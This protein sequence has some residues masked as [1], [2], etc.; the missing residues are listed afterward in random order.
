M[1]LVRHTSINLSTCFRFTLRY[2]NKSPYHKNCLLLPLLELELYRLKLEVYKS[3][4]ELYRL[5][6]EVYRSKLELY[7]L[8][9]EIYRLKLELYT[10]FLGLNS[11]YLKF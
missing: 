9:L 6:L 1:F 10:S 3:K 5:K 11:Y 7:R 4:L 8:M 2:N